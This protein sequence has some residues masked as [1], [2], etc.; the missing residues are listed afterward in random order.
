[1]DIPIKIF[2]LTRPR[3]TR[4]L[5]FRAFR[6][7]TRISTHASAWDAANCRLRLSYGL[8]NFNSRVRAGRDELPP[9]GSQST[10][11]S[12]HASARD[13]TVQNERFNGYRVISTH[14]SARDA[15]RILPAGV[16][17]CIGFQLTRPRGTRLWRCLMSVTLY[18]NFNSRVRAGRDTRKQRMHWRKPISTH[19]SAR[20]ATYAILPYGGCGDFNSRV[21]AGR[22]ES[23]ET[24]PMRYRHF[25]SRVRA[26][27]DATA[28][29]LLVV[30]GNFNS[31][32]RAGRDR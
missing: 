15:T 29:A 5:A 13:A 12:T 28:L 18:D 9:D 23:S 24:K 14:A 27:R 11:I 2:Q 32:V 26:G 22:D 17:F 16:T 7:G 6:V 30:F 19:A 21:R 31:R 20:D 1:M 3:G 8:W 4:P 10:P 25:N